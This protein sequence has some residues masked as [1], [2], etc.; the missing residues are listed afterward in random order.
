MRMNTF[1]AAIAVSLLL[2]ACVAPGE[3]DRKNAVAPGEASFD[4]A[5]ARTAA[6]AEART[7]A[8]TPSPAFGVVSRA[9]TS[10]SADGSRTLDLESP[11]SSYW[12][13]PE[14]RR[15]LYESYLAETDV[16]PKF[17]VVE[18]SFL[19]QFFELMGQ[20]KQAEAI[21][22]LNSK[23][24][25]SASAIFDMQ[26]AVQYMQAERYDDAVEALEIAVRKHPKF[27]RAWSSLG[28]AWFRKGDPAKTIQALT[29]AIE[30]GVSDPITFGML[31]ICYLNTDDNLAAESAYRMAI[32]LDPATEDWKTGLAQSLFKQR[33]FPEVVAL[34]DTLLAARPD[35]HDL[36][37]RQAHAYLSMQMPMRAAENFEIIERMGKLDA[38][39][40][41]TLGDI[42]VGEDLFGLAV[43]AYSKAIEADAGVGPDRAIKGARVIAGRGGHDEAQALIASVEGAFPNMDD[44][45]RKDVLR[46]R[47]RLAVATGASEEEARVLE[48]IV[49]LDPLDGQALIMLGMHAE[50]S[51]DAEKAILYYE[52]AEAL[53]AFEAEAK[54]RHAQALVRQGKYA[55]AVPLLRRAQAIDFRENIQQFLEDVEKVSLRGGQ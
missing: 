13:D 33:R 18:A 50:R 37:M 2:L 9:P 53:E 14:F 39:N 30:N 28:I 6:I 27:R 7:L 22:L 23:R 55:P 52:R 1:P 49:A 41:N 25:D 35:R 44:Q 54:V 20:D 11:D 36:W 15:R 46:L 26:L 42:Y 48:E 51:G 31:G 38:A 24:S 17:N 34:C 40:L 47:A 45:Q 19:Q 32:L 16:E 3:S 10:S 21:A 43:N 8:A 4:L 5:A 29:K 12:R